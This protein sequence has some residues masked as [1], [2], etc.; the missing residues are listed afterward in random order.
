MHEV[1]PALR[2]SAQQCRRCGRT[3]RPSGPG[4][5][6]P[7]QHCHANGSLRGRAAAGDALE[8][9]AA[10]CIPAFEP[11]HCPGAAAVAAAAH[12][13]IVCVRTAWLLRRVCSGLPLY[14]NTHT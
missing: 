11:G 4:R 9:A 10:E 8:R 1:A 5:V 14:K 12:Y 7:K 2:E 3:G 6:E 13:T